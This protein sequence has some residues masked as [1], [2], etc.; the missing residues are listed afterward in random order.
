M[1]MPVF[2]NEQ[3]LQFLDDLRETGVTNMFG[4]APYVTAQFPSLRKGEAEA[5]LKYWMRTFEVRHR[6]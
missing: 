5:I 4:A 1:I 3:H 6:A 2:C